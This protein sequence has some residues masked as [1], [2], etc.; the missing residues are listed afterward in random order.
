LTNAGAELTGPL[1]VAF[2]EVPL[3]FQPLPSRDV[4]ETNRASGDVPTRTK[5]EH[6]LARLDRGESFAA[7]CPCPL[8][9][10]RFGNGLLLIAVGGEPVIDYAHELKRRHAG[11]GRVVW[12]AGYANDMF[13]YLPTAGVLRGGGYEGTRSILWSAMPAPFA[14]TAEERVLAGVG[15]LV[16]QLG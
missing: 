6:L 7:T 11:P 10:A 2:E 4:L 5:A 8:Q 15:R 9:V 16:E 13:G 3:E 1:Q 12:V 14:E